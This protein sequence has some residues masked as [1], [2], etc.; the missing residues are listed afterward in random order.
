MPAKKN[1]TTQYISDMQ[2]HNKVNFPETE[3]MWS[4]VK[5]TLIASS[6]TAAITLVGFGII[7]YF[8][9]ASNTGRIFALENETVRRDVQTEI[10]KNIYDKLVVLTTSTQNLDSAV[11]DLNKYLLNNK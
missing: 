8:A 7:T 9:V 2:K 10:D 5:K 11:T 1:T 6:I 3:D 4:E